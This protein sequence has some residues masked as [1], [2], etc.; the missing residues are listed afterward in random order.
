MVMVCGSGSRAARVWI[1]AGRQ[2][3]Q[4]SW[5]RAG[6]GDGSVAGVAAVIESSRPIHVR[7]NT[8]IVAS[9]VNESGRA[10]P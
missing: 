1:V 2:G 9:V 8:D 3:N 7:V 10:A 4:G 6:F 5:G